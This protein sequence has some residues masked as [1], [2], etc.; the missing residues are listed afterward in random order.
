[1]APAL[2]HSVAVLQGGW[3]ELLEDWARRPARLMDWPTPLLLATLLPL[4]LFTL[5]SIDARARALGGSGARV[6][7]T[8]RFQARLFAAALMPIAGYV[9]LSSALGVIPQLRVNVETVAVWNAVYAT[10]LLVLFAA[11]VPWL[12]RNTWQT[13]ELP[14]GSERSL[15]ESVARLANFRC[16]RLL[17]WRTG[18]SVANAAIVGLF[19]RQRAV[20]FTDLLLAQLDLRQLASVFAHEIGHAKIDHVAIFAA[21]AFAALFGADLLS[22]EIFPDDPAWASALLLAAMAR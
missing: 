9:L 5:L 6:R 21:W 10:V 13:V 14:E 2:L 20:L 22:A 17:V 19:S 11:G 1:M 12:L 16:R 8:L 15:L 3:L 4:A 18:N 7:E